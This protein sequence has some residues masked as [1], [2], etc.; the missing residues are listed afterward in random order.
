MAVMVASVPVETIRTRSAAGTRS[1]T[2]A[3]RL[4]SSAVDGGVDGRED[5]RVGVSQQRRAP[6]ADQVDVLGPVSI[7][8]VRA[9]GGNHKARCAAHRAEGPD[10]RVDAAGHQSAGTVE[11]F[12]V[13]RLAGSH[14]SY[15]FSGSHNGWSRVGAASASRAATRGATSVPNSSMERI[16]AA[17]GSVPLLYLRSKRSTPRVR[18]SRA[19]LAAT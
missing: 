16:M 15:S 8:Q 2:S 11:K 13:A 7:G 6:R 18:L 14:G 10:R 5:R 17:C 19:I 4:A 3:A 9:L 1:W 12:L